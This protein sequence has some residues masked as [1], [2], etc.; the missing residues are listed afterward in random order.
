MALWR[1]RSNVVRLTVPTEQGPPHMVSYSS[2][3]DCITAAS[4]CFWPVTGS[5]QQR[6]SIWSTQKAKAVAV[7]KSSLSISWRP[8]S[9]S[10]RSS[11]ELSSRGSTKVDCCDG[12]HSCSTWSTVWRIEFFRYAILSAPAT[13][14]EK[15]WRQNRR[16]R[17]STR[18][19]RVLTEGSAI[20]PDWKTSN[21]HCCSWNKLLSMT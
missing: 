6:S 11:L 21:L 5:W 13:S 14:T 20:F 19:A 3:V 10:R 12:W 18:L 16:P 4:R 8:R 17:Y 2:N 1:T 7:R 15:P 9:S